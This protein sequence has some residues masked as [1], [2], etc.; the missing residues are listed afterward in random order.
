MSY[1]DSYARTITVAARIALGHGLSNADIRIITRDVINAVT[2]VSDVAEDVSPITPTFT[3]NEG[4]QGMGDYFSDAIMH[5]ERA[6]A[7]HDEMTTEFLLS[8]GVHP[9]DCTD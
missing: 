1:A 8:L 7:T 6:G 9:S 5:L 2:G 3:G 4:L